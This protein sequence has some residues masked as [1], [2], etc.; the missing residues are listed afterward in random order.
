M[1]VVVMINGNAEFKQF[2]ASWI[3]SKI[4]KISVEAHDAD[5]IREIAAASPEFL[6]LFNNWRNSED[7]ENRGWGSAT[8]DVEESTAM[9]LYI[10]LEDHVMLHEL[11][12]F[13]ISH[14]KNIIC[15]LENIWKNGYKCCINDYGL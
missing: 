2:F 10:G 14:Y 13:V 5:Y 7:Y 15:V 8:F 11:R 9:N 12:H 4:M 3:G 6:Y 1:K